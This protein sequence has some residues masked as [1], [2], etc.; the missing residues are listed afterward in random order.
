MS[1]STSSIFCSR[2]GTND[3]KALFH[4]HSGGGAGSSSVPS[5]Y[6]CDACEQML[7]APVRSALTQLKARLEEAKQSM[8]VGGEVTRGRRWGLSDAIKEIEKMEREL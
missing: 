5:Y 1:S 6:L 4:V 2:C 8:L 3:G 7:D